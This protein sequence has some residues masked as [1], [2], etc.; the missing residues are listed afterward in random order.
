MKRHSS[1]FNGRFVRLFG[2]SSLNRASCPPYPLRWSVLGWSNAEMYRRKKADVR[3]VS[4]AQYLNC[5][6][7]DNPDRVL[8]RHRIPLPERTWSFLILNARIDLSKWFLRDWFSI[9]VQ[10]NLISPSLIS[11]SISNLKTIRL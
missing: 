8:Q 1:V 6:S 11:W 9:G 2:M 5:G 4:D 7:H 10:V 3:F